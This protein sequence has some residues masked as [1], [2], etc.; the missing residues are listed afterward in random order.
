MRI[1]LA[2]ALVFAVTPVAYGQRTYRLVAVTPHGITGRA[3]GIDGLGEVT[4]VMISSGESHAML[5][6][7][8]SLYDL[9][10]LGGFSSEGLAINSSGH[11]VGDAERANGQI[12]AFLYRGG[13]LTDLGFAVDSLA[14]GINGS[15]QIV[16]EVNPGRRNG[17]LYDHGSVQYLGTL[18][19]G[20][21]SE[22][23]S[24]NDSGLVTGWADSPT[25]FGYNASHAILFSGAALTDLGTLL[26]DISSL[27]MGINNLGHITGSSQSGTASRA[28]LYD[29]TTMRSISTLPWSTYGK[30]IND[31]DEVVGVVDSSPSGSGFL[32]SDGTCFWL[33]ALIDSSGDGYGIF[34]TAIDDDHLIAGEAASADEDFAV[35]LVPEDVRLVTPESFRLNRGNVDSGGLEDLFYSDDDAMTL[36]NGISPFASDYPISITLT[37]HVPILMP[38][39]L[40][41]GVES[42]VQ[43]AQLDQTVDV[44]DYVSGSYTQVDVRPGSLSD[45]LAYLS[46]N[47]PSR[48]IDPASGE[49]KMRIKYRAGSVLPGASWTA[50]VDRAI[51]EEIP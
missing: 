9:G 5:Y 49:V 2:M 47:N 11:I 42:H 22:A 14:F 20:R 35:L 15:D 36:R 23:R 32:Y 37:A 40:K 24:I 16:G 19:G 25:S 38:S 10:T 44:F 4:G 1:L 6:S 7:G 18:P 21:E 8:G 43:L 45:A 48:Y 34:P 31:L 12:A 17:F 46:L 33:P 50:G 13:S 3:F 26:G 39:G 41:I 30:S 29:G 27:G 28:F 51:W